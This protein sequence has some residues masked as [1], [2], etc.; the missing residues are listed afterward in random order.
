MRPCKFNDQPQTYQWVE[1]FVNYQRVQYWH[2]DCSNEEATFIVLV[3]RLGN[4]D[5]MI[6]VIFTQS[7]EKKTN[8]I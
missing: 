5:T 6:K 1:D 7:A 2:Q 4:D 3:L 8:Q